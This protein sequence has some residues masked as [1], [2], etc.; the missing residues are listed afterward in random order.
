M[1]KKCKVKFKSAVNKT[2]EKL[3]YADSD[4]WGPVRVASKAIL[5]FFLTFINDFSREVWV[6]FMRYKSEVF[7]NFR[8]WKAKVEIQT[9]KE[10]SASGQ[11][12]GRNTG[13]SHL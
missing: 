10:L 2:N 8:V 6:Y 9:W 4:V 13:S 11:I 12:M 7:D 5:L 1:G 3:D